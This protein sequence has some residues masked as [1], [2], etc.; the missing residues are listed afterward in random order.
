MYTFD[1]RVR[2]SEVDLN[3]YLDIS[4]VINYFQDCSTFHSEAVGLGIEYLEQ[5]H[6]V[7][8]LNS[9]QIQIHRLP[10]L[11]EHISTGTWAYDFKNFYGYRN[12][13]MKDE[14]KQVLAVANSVWIYLDTD[15]FR[16]VKVQKEDVDGYTL[17]PQFEMDYTG[18]KIRLPESFVTHPNFQ[19]VK[20]NID[21]NNHV[22][23]G[24]YIKMA[25]EYLPSGFKV[26]QIRAEYRKS[27]LLGDTMLP[28]VTVEA[29]T[30]TVALCSTD[31][32]PYAVIEF[33]QNIA[34]LK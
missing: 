11:G 17:E 19:V 24:Q 30:V 16:P 32:T 34:C 7:W 4:N 1:S 25:E 31:L 5:H 22:N 27:A 12:F 21:T 9:W 18:R 26:S 13:I 23:N 10:K 33:K 3:Q 29:D 28:H 2:Y 14:K 8:L 20:S 6:R 15:T